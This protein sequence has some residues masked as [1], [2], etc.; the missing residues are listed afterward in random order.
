MKTQ[1]D[2]KNFISDLA[3]L[4]ESHRIGL[5]AVPIG[6]YVPCDIILY[7]MDDN[8]EIQQTTIKTE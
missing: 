1:K 8:Q 2:Y 4:Q 7:D 3:K 6:Q 5:K